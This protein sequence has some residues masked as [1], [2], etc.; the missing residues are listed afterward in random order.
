V[1]SSI[2]AREVLET[3]DITLNSRSFAARAIHAYLLLC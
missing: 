2:V 3:S 1:V